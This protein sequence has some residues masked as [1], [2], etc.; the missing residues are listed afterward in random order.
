MKM[1]GNPRLFLSL[2]FGVMRQ[3]ADMV[4]LKH[5]VQPLINIKG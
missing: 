4:E 1:A 5:H 2:V 3:Q